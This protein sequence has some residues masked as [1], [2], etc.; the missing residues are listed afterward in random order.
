[1]NNQPCS[2]CEV[3]RTPLGIRVLDDLRSITNCIEDSVSA[4]GAKCGPILGPDYPVSESSC[5]PIPPYPEYF[6]EISKIVS[7]LTEC[8][9]Q[10]EL[11]TKRVEL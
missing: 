3:A 4:I 2:P 5:D 6:A 9:K 8:D 10:L 7:R 1:M 11:L